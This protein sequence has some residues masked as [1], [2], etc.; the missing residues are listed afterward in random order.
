MSNRKEINNELQQLGAE[1][2][3][4]I[5]P[6]TPSIP[7]DNYL[8]N[9]KVEKKDTT[10]VI[11]LKPYIIGIGVAA[12]ITL[13]VGISFLFQKNIPQTQVALQETS[14]DHSFDVLSESIEYVDE[15]LLYETYLS[16]QEEEVDDIESYLLENDTDID[17]LIDQL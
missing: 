5:T 8:E 6:R 11:Q 17:L 12:S 10:K 3:K 15:E 9:F 16:Y 1:K 14:V 2:L 7:Q 4:G 13:L